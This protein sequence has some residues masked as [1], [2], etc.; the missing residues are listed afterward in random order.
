MEEE[1]KQKQPNNDTRNEFDY[2][3][4]YKSQ[5]KE[6][7]IINLMLNKRVTVGTYTSSLMALDKYVDDQLP[8]L[9]RHLQDKFALRFKSWDDLN[10]QLSLYIA[11]LPLV[12]GDCLTLA[13]AL[14]LLQESQGP[15]S[16]VADLGC[17]PR[18]PYQP[19][20]R[21]KRRKK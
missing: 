16:H 7:Q 15:R 3:K 2:L 20:C 4:E 6:D 13:G 17:F 9:S 1:A 10:K 5:C 19:G 18:A 14:S 12:D 21:S 8:A 11:S